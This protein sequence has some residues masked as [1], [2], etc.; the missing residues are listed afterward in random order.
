MSLVD[1]VR[2]AGIIGCGGAGFP[3]HVKIAST[4]NTVIA[5]GAE[6]EPLLNTDQRVMELFADELIEGLSLVMQNTGATRGMIALK[7]SYHEA[8]AALSSRLSP[9]SGI[10][11]ALLDNFYPAGDEQILLTEVT[12]R[13]VPEGGIP[14]NVQA[15]ISNVYTLVQ[16]ARAAKGIPATERVLT[17]T[18]DVRKPQVLAVP[19]GTSVRDLLTLALPAIPVDAIAVIDGGPMMGRIVDLDS[20]INK[21]TSGLIFLHREH[22]II[23]TRQLPLNAIIRRSVAAC[24]QCRLCT[25][26]CSRYLQGHHIEPHLMMRSLAYQL[27]SPTEAMTGAFLC[28]QCGLCEFACPMNLSPR[29]AFAEILKRFS[30]G[31]MKNPHHNAPTAV[32]EFNRFRKLDK[33]RLT[34]RYQLSDYERHDLPFSSMPPP[35]RVR[36]ALKQSIGAPSE[37]VVKAG[38]RVKKNDLVAKIPDGKLGS[39]LHASM[40][41]TV[42]EVTNSTITVEGK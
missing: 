40:D 26:I 7:K 23:Q 15:V 6:C 30:A 33:D 29:R 41:G 14:L 4:V 9:A 12:D 37:P 10:E 3:T 42:V 19:V 35:S 38:A 18:G 22:P 34:L 20:S 1:Q 5:N 13:I 21:T 27:D 11:L 28:S 36:L 2:D 39:N 31:G 32:H 24:C 17:M 8:R 16:I 25:D